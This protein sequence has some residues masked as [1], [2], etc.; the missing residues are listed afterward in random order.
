MTWLD[1]LDRRITTRAPKGPQKSYRYGAIHTAFVVSV[2]RVP[3]CLIVVGVEWR[4][5]DIWPR[6]SPITWASP[7]PQKSYRYIATS[8]AFTDGYK[9]A[10]TRA[11]THK[12]LIRGWLRESQRGT[13][14]HSLI[15]SHAILFSGG[16]RVVTHGCLASTVAYQLG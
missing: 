3:F 10:R 15:I 6:P 14:T 1:V 12:K 11:H 2:C 16:V 13:P 8:I 7:G 4:C 5:V 9:Q